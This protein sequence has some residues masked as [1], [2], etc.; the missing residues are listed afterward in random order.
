MWEWV[1]KNGWLSKEE[2]KELNTRDR[3]IY[4]EMKQ[5]GDTQYER[6]KDQDNDI[7]GKLVIILL[8]MGI[9]FIFSMIYDE[10]YISLGTGLTIYA[11]MIL[12]SIKK[13]ITGE[14]VQEHKSRVERIR[15][16]PEKPKIVEV[17]AII[18]QIENKPKKRY[19]W[20]EESINRL[21]NNKDIKKW[22]KISNKCNKFIQ[23]FIE[24]A[25]KGYISDEEMEEINVYE[26]YKF[27]HKAEYDEVIK[28]MIKIEQE[29]S[30]QI[31]EK[32][33]TILEEE[34]EITEKMSKEEQEE[35]KNDLKIN[36]KERLANE[37]KNE[38][39]EQKIERWYDKRNKQER[40]FILQIIFSF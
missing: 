39:E 31:E 15:F 8:L 38:E 20:S 18:P 11:I 35:L 5:E 23:N 6:M 26:Q 24:Q 4:R 16:A 14:W 13:N 25:R 17:E 27:E 12:R 7:S 29:G 1:K 3:Q 32:K 28:D 22:C 19:Y 37:I 9:S 21:L 34:E 30:S 36:W 2:E 10:I 40:I 33:E